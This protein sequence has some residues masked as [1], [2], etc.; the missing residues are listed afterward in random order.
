MTFISK[1]DNTK[2]IIT[3]INIMYYKVA[4]TYIKVPEG[5]EETNAYG[6]IMLSELL[7]LYIQTSEVSIKPVRLVGFKLTKEDLKP[8]RT[9]WLKENLKESV[10]IDING[11][12]YV[13]LVFNT[14]TETIIER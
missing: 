10:Y 8:Y 6:V 14:G 1:T 5:K 4:F 12:P 9:K 11:K 3:T 7:E 13:M 2:L